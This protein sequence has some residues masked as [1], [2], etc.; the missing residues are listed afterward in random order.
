[1]I[2]KNR[3]VQLLVVCIAIHQSFSLG[4]NDLNEPKKQTGRSK[5]SKLAARIANKLLDFIPDRYL[6]KFYDHEQKNSRRFE[7]TG[8]CSNSQDVKNFF[9]NVYSNNTALDLD[10]EELETLIKFQIQRG[11]RPDNYENKAAYYKCD[12]KKVSSQFIFIPSLKNRN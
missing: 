3:L 8:N 1:M 4:F 10:Q 7:P 6:D 2:L 9:F 5:R 11:E 12:R